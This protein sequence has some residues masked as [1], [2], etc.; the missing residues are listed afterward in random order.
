MNNIFHDVYDFN[1]FFFILHFTFYFFHDT[2]NYKLKRHVLFSMALRDCNDPF[3]N[4][5]CISE[6]YI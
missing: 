3:A 2:I 6:Q 5:L 1:M 4:Y